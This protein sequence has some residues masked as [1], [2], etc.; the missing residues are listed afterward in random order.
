MKDVTKNI[1]YF[2]PAKAKLLK[3]TFG[4]TSL[5]IIA[6][7]DKKH[8]TLKFENNEEKIQIQSSNLNLVKMSNP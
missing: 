7:K 2:A 6:P 5:N 3:Q 1:Y 8:Y 4:D